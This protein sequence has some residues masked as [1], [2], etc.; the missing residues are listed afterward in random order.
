[1]G[2]LSAIWR[3]LKKYFWILLIIAIIVL[4]VYFPEVLQSIW[5]WMKTMWSTFVKWY[6]DLD[7][8][9]QALIALGAAYIVD[10]EAVTSFITHA[11]ST[12]GNFISDVAGAAVS[13]FFSSPMGWLLIAGGAYLVFGRKGQDGQTF[14][15][16][17]RDPAAPPE[18][19]ATL[20][21]MVV[22]P[23]PAPR[24]RPAPAKL[25]PLSPKVAT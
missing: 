8:W 4:A 17:H 13:G 11:V 18:A 7:W 23:Q 12:V 15:Q 20:D 3:K 19:T 16:R 10:S 9:A 5:T 22:T 2:I 25:L 1:M 24:Q 6:K 21:T 14:Y